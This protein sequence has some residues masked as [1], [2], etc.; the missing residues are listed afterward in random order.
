MTNLALYP[1]SW[2]DTQNDIIK[3]IQEAEQLSLIEKTQQEQLET[4]LLKLIKSIKALGSVIEVNWVKFEREQTDEELNHLEDLSQRIQETI[5]NLNNNKL[6]Q[7]FTQLI[8]SLTFLSD[9]LN[10][11]VKN[12]RLTKLVREVRKQPQTVEEELE[13]DRIIKEALAS[14]HQS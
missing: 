10:E 13:T 4:Y 5:A 9:N 8:I 7:D 12:E 14:E 1:N 2:L 6:N 11:I 3:V